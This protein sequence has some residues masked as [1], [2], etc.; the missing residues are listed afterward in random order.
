MKE[1]SRKMQ[2][3]SFV[4][5]FRSSFCVFFFF[6]LSRVEFSF[7]STKY[8]VSLRSN[9]ATVALNSLFSEKRKTV[10]ILSDKVNASHSLGHL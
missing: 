10:L 5:P 9:L 1:G 3:M 2:T 7:V 8:V 4:C 6:A